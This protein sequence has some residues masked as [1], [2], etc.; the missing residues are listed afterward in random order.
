M[1]KDDPGSYSFI[2]YEKLKQELS[3][4][5]DEIGPAR[6]KKIIIKVLSGLP[7]LIIEDIL[8]T[9]AILIQSVMSPGAGIKVHLQNTIDS[10]LM[11]W[12]E[13]IQY[14]DAS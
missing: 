2:I 11:I 8:N 3:D 12:N 9:D 5:E 13:R 10:I 1:K 6:A 4:S 14:R 7:D